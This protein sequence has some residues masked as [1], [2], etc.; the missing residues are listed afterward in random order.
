[1]GNRAGSRRRNCP[2]EQKNFKRGFESTA[3]GLFF[4]ARLSAFLET[5]SVH[6]FIFHIVDPLLYSWEGSHHSF[7]S[8][9]GKP[10]MLCAKQMNCFFISGEICGDEPGI[11]LPSYENTL[12]WSG[13]SRTTKT[14]NT[15]YQAKMK[16]WM[17]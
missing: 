4:S 7:R 13:C 2:A 15:D 8:T 3:S 16:E 6:T 12:R 5:C 14:E 11:P 9:D 17:S 10:V 1:M